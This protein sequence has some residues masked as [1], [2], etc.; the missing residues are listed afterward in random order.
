[1]YVFPLEDVSQVLN[2]QVG[3]TKLKLSCD[4]SAHFLCLTHPYKSRRQRVASPVPGG[5]GKVLH[6]SGRREGQGGGGVC[7]GACAQ[8]GGWAPA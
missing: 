4:G 7:P 8:G 3:F 1:M 6:L 2:W 5:P